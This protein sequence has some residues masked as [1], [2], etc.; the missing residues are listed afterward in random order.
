[1]ERL[2]LIGG[3]GHCRSVLDTA[4]RMDV[5]EEIVITDCS[6]PVGTEFMG[7]RVVGTDELLPRLF[8]DGFRMAFI[9]VG[10]IKS[11]NQR[12]VI[13][14]RAKKAGFQFA[15]VIDPSALVSDYAVVGTGI[16]VGKRAVINAGAYIQDMA[17]INTGAIIEHECHVG[18]YSHVAV[19]AVV[20][21]G[22]DIGDSVFIGANATVVQGIK[23]G[24]N[25]IIGAG[26]VVLKNVMPNSIIRT[27][28]KENG[29]DADYSGGRGES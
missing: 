10:S 21:G 16:Y 26:C 29:K 14:Q 28:R 27:E 20:C 7:C 24:M 3:G 11:T 25:S 18:N 9:S 23:V 13:C 8:Q 4:R 17:I 22:S 15:N 2:V 19:G 12:K 5:F 1:M 6:I